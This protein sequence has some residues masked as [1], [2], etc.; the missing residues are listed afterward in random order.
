MGLA[1]DAQ[2]ELK[3]DGMSFVF[4]IE[5][6]EP[7]Q[8]FFVFVNLIPYGWGDKTCAEYFSKMGKVR[9]VMKVVFDGCM[10]TEANLEFYEQPEIF[11][12]FEGRQKFSI[13]FEGQKFRYKLPS[14]DKKGEEEEEP[15]TKKQKTLEQPEPK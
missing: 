1:E 3:L 7:K 9:R 6:K 11:K 10:T 8:T 4:L 2:L 14:A 12:K 5:N 13:Q 15:E